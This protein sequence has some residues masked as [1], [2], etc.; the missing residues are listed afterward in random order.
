MS[1]AAPTNLSEFRTAL[2]TAARAC[3]L[4]D[5]AA[6]LEGQAGPVYELLAGDWDFISTETNDLTEQGSEPT[7]ARA[8]WAEFRDVYVE[9]LWNA[10]RTTDVS[11]Q[12]ATEKANA[13]A[14]LL[15]GGA[16]GA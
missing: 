13:I 14:D 1:F 15:I 8:W 5:F 7:T 4:P 9:T 11:E 3:A 6:A 10:M 12:A 2:A 16:D